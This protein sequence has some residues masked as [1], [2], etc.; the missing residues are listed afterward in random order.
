MN[1]ITTLDTERTDLLKALAKAR[2]FL[3]FTAQNLT[4]EQAASTPTASALCIGGLIKH[5]TSVERNWVLFIQEGAPAQ[6]S[7]ED[8]DWEARA[9]EFRLLPDESLADVIADYD[10]AAEETA[11]VVAELD[12]LDVSH[13]LPEAPWFE[14]DSWTARTVLMHIIAETAQHSGHAD[15]IR[16]TID[17]QKSMG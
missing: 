6:S 1:A 8:V 14:K 5:V 7:F 12:S 15:I 9:K 10:R 4:H 11:Q 13:P 2:H 17:G 16:E 3:K